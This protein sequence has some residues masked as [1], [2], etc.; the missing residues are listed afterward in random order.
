MYVCVSVYICVQWF[1]YR[2][3]GRWCT[4]LRWRHW[5]AVSLFSSFLTPLTSVRKGH[6]KMTAVSLCLSVCPS[7][8]RMPRNNSRMERPRKTKI[9]RMEVHH[10]GN[11]WTYLEVKVTRMEHEDPCRRQAPW[12]PTQVA[13]SRGVSDRCWPIGKVAHFT[14]YNAHRLQLLWSKATQCTISRSWELQFSENYLVWHGIISFFKARELSR[15]PT[16]QWSTAPLHLTF[17]LLL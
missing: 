9:G 8:C 12:P 3:W 13:R 11:S 1:S 15:P 4:K 2:R 6:Y 14:D 17:M 16:L 5:H 10:S 7:V